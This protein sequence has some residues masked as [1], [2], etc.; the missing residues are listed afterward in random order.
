MKKKI[1]YFDMDGVLADYEASATNK[2][3]PEKEDDGFFTQ[4]KPIN[5]AIDAFK[6]LSEHFDCYILT[7]APWS[8][9]KAMSEKRIWVENHLGELAFKRLMTSHRKDLHIGDYLI[10]DRTVNGAGEFSGTH[11]H[12]GTPLFPDWETIVEFL[13]KQTL[14]GK[15]RDILLSNHCNHED[16][17]TGLEETAN[18]IMTL[19]KEEY[20]Y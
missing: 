20:G 5:G 16:D 12:F 13:M 6:T 4:L 17:T 18:E 1:I 19:I 7:T 8:S 2:E 9:P 10:D 11:I 15:I 14:E 3:A